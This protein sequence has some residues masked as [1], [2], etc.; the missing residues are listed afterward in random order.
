MTG[1]LHYIEEMAYWYVMFF[2]QKDSLMITAV[3]LVVEDAMRIPF[4]LKGVD[5]VFHQVSIGGD[6]F[7]KI[8]KVQV[9]Q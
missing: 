2:E 5:V 1:W 9:K 6:I 7:A 3:P 8:Q 4:E